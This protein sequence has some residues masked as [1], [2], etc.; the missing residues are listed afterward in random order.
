[1][2]N[3]PNA[4]LSINEAS[5]SFA[6]G[7]GLCVVMACVSKNADSVPRVMGS[8]QGLLAEYNYSPGIDYAALHIAA[9]NKPVMFVGLPIATAGTVGSQSN[10]GVTGTCL[11]S[12]A[13]AASGILEKVQ[14]IVTCTKGTVVGTDQISL[15]LSMD[16]GMTYQ[17][18]RLGSATSYTVPQLGIVISF[19]AGTL[20]VGDTFTFN[21]TAP[22][23]GS[24]AIA[25]AEAALAAQQQLA[26][27]WMIAGNLPSS[28]FAGYVTT[29]TNLYETSVE[30]YV[31]ARTSV[32]DRL[33]LAVNSQ[34]VV[35]DQAAGS[36]TF[37]ATT[38]TRT[39]GSWITDGFAVGDMV[40]LSGTAANSGTFGPITTLTATVLTVSSATW[41]V[42]T[43]ASSLVVTGAESLVF[44]SGTTITRSGDV[45][46]GVAGSWLNDGFAVGQ[47]VAITG[48]TSNNV[49]AVIT[50]L[51]A[52]VMTCSATTF[53]AETNSVAKVKVLQVNADGAFV[54]SQTSAFATVDAQKRI[55]ISLGSAFAPPSP[56]TG[57]EFARP[58]AWPLSIREYQ[59]DLQIPSWRKSDGPLL[60]WSL[61][62]ANG[63]KV[64]HDERVDGGALAGRFSCLRSYANGPIGAFGALSL[65]RDT[66][67]AFLSR[68]QNI[69]VADLACGVVQAATEN[70]IGTVL[71]LN[72]NGTA[73]TAS[74]SLLAQRVNKQLAIN[75]LQNFSEGPRA[76]SA[77]W[78]PSTTDILNTP[79]ATLNG[80]LALVLDGTLEQIATTVTVS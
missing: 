21:T 76:S 51:T 58:A 2:A 78:T 43:D 46:A 8:V 30:R 15:N 20:N 45:A 49:T 9:T 33:P 27:S 35:T 26:R 42:E 32:P 71:A 40:T 39:T 57:W 18:V 11:I 60:G 19:G 31:Y 34:V 44:A 23:W 52:T 37:A 17:P 36:C 67:G 7:N 53:T 66:E 6:G 14:G 73:T 41:T 77:I 16:N 50:T 13:A 75:L 12:V 70:A 55:D 68:T 10:L 28:T 22:M 1:M 56:I 80:N 24:T 38:I 47:T 65:T 62:D 48:S 63:N 5:A 3:L 64:F 72:T 4:T 59:H 74:L 29:S 54:S 61:T 79:G 69:A 25:T